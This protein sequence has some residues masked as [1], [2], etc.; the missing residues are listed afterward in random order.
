MITLA[1]LPN[2]TP[3]EVFDQAV[4]HILTQNAKASDGCIC[5][6]R[7]P[8][9]LKCAAG[10]F[11]SDTEYKEQFENKNWE[12]LVIDSYVPNE[13]DVLICDL[14]CVHDNNK[15]EEWPLELKRLASIHNLN[16]NVLKEFASEV[17]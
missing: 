7:S 16:D 4:R 15:I 8:K 14:Q 17:L 1:T 2:A 10:C 12:C 9:G 13:H 6:Y 5:F 3:Q 11:I